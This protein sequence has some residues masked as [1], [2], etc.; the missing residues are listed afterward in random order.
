MDLSVSRARCVKLI[1][2]SKA[3]AGEAA[4]VAILKRKDPSKDKVRDALAA[5]HEVESMMCQTLVNAA[6]ACLTKD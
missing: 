3:I 1:A 4:L 5:I 6:R 2:V